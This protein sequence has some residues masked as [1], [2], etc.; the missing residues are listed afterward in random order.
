VFFEILY[1]LIRADMTG[2]S[3][4]AYYGGWSNDWNP[5]IRELEKAG[6]LAVRTDE[7]DQLSV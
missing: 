1:Q 3:A 6:I 4:F 5:Q 7:Y 2:Q